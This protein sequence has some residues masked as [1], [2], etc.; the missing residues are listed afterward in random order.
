[1]NRLAI[2]GASGHGKVIADIAECCGWQVIDFFD[3]AWPDVACIGSWNVVG[4]TNT[5]ISKL[6]EYTGVVVA[7]GNNKIRNRK[8]F[9]LKEL[10]AP[11]VS[12]VH[13]S[14]TVSR[15]TVIGSGSVLMAGV[16]VNAGTT[17]GD[18]AILNTCCSVDHDCIL[19]D[20]VHVSPGAHLAGNV[21]LGDASWVG[22]GAS[23]RQGIT[24]GANV[25]VGAGATVVSDF[26][27]DVIVTGVP[28]RI[29]S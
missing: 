27:D 21:C 2:L 14:A 7:I 5:L 24:L 28:A 17:I 15:Y 20:G 10:K 29:K 25:T 12:L 26:P 23:V 11:L 16:V 9:Q 13:P 19:G 18:G 8:M 1:M 6:H 22:I 3:D 4:V